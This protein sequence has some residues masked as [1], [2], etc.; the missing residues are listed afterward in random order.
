MPPH[1]LLTHML[2][3]N[4]LFECCLCEHQLQEERHLE[5]DNDTGGKGMGA[6]ISEPAHGEASGSQQGDQRQSVA[7]E[8]SEEDED[9]SQ[10]EVL[11]KQGDLNAL[12][13]LLAR[14]DIQVGPD[15]SE[16]QSSKKKKKRKAKQSSRSRSRR[17]RKKR[18][19]STSSTSRLLGEDGYVKEDEGDVKEEACPGQNSPVYE[20]DEDGDGCSLGDKLQRWIK[21]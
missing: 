20:S 12:Y 11:V 9:N 19:S 16:A 8:T 14:V 17:R 5:N 3:L 6:A 13:R 15:E 4:C 18:R 10:V 7:E 1:R 21:P 2:L